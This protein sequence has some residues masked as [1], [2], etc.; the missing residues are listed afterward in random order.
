[1]KNTDVMN[2]LTNKYW[3]FEQLSGELDRLIST[4]KEIASNDNEFQDLSNKITSDLFDVD[5]ALY[6]L[7]SRFE[8]LVSVKNDS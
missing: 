1:M 6:E 7:K 8:K 2:K 4:T 5:V 3:E